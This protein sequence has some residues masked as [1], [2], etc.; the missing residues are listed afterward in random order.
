MKN[1]EFI[2]KARPQLAHSAE[3]ERTFLVGGERAPRR[4]RARAEGPRRHAPA[5]RRGRRRGVLPR[6]DRPGHRAGAG[7]A[8]GLGDRGRPG[9]LPA[10][11]GHAA[12]RHLPRPRGVRAA[13]AD[14]RAPVAPDAPP[15]GGVR[16]PG[17]GPQL[18]RVPP[19]LHRGGQGRLGGPGRARRPAAGCPDRR[20]HLAALRRRAAHAH[21]SRSARASPAASGGAPSAWPARSCP[22]IRPTLRRSTRRTSR[23][24][25]GTARS[26][27]SPRRSAARSAPA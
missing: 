23:S 3:A 8:G 14:E 10:D 22:A 4:D 24:P 15:P 25:T 7:G 12:R 20:P 16:P 1:V 13:A 6:A 19:P 21:R 26:S 2:G 9:H 18:G 17:H 11:V 27:R 5:D